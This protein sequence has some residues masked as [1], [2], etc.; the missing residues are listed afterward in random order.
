MPYIKQDDRCRFEHWLKG[1]ALSPPKSA[2]ELN[3]LITKLCHIYTGKDF[4][5][6][7]INDVLGALTGAQIE[8]YRRLAVPYEEEKIEQNG[9]I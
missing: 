2:G 7:S 6:Q 9:D 3:Y 4:N 8:F 5:Y 1:A